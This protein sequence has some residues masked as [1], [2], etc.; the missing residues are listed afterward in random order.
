[1][2][3]SRFLL[4]ALNIWNNIRFQEHIRKTDMELC[5]ISQT[6]NGSKCL[7]FNVNQ[8]QFHL[9]FLYIV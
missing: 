2:L 5:P 3:V 8:T 9:S 4:F 6:A 7:F 1:M